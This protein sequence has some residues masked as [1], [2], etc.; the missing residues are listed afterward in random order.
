MADV[1]SGVSRD[2]PLVG[3]N[4]PVMSFNKVDLP[5][6]FGPIKTA[7]L[8]QST[9]KSVCRTSNFLLYGVPA[10]PGRAVTPVPYRNPEN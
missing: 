2:E 3:V 5:A 6:P 10:R 4:S 1:Q 9:P 8:S 7:R